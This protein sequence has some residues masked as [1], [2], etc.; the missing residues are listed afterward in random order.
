MFTFIDLVYLIKI[1][2]RAE[3]Q[4]RKYSLKLRFNNISTSKQSAE[5]QFVGQN[6]QQCSWYFY[7]I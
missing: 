5:P 3:Q 1:Y 2:E 7:R 4:A 6:T